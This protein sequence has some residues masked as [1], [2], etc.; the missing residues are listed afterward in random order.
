MQTQAFNVFRHGV[1]AAPDRHARQDATLQA[2]RVGVGLEAHALGRLAIDKLLLGGVVCSHLI[3]QLQLDGGEVT[4]EGLQ[5]ELLGGKI[6]GEFTG[7]FTR[8]PPAYGLYVA[9]LLQPLAELSANWI[10]TH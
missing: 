7:D 2:G 6:G 9:A 8:H 5:G 1:E 3:S 4:M 10:S